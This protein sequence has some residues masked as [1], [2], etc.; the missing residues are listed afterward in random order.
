MKRLLPWL[1][2]FRLFVIL[3]EALKKTILC[4]EEVDVG[5]VVDNLLSFPEAPEVDMLLA[6]DPLECKGQRSAA[7]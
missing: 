4:C 1:S 2:R 5:E 6:L 7:F 3:S